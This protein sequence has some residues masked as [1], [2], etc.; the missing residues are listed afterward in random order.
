M[1]WI[2]NE[3]YIIMFSTDYT[4]AKIVSFLHSELTCQTESYL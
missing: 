1:L 3:K 2:Q 4:P